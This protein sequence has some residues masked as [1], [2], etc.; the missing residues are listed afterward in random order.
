MECCSC[1]VSLIDLNS[2]ISA[3]LGGFFALLGVIIT[4]IWE[5][6]KIHQE[7][8]ESA[9]PFFAMIDLGDTRV[10]DSNNHVFIFSKNEC[11]DHREP[12][13]QANFIN[14]GK[15]EFLIEKISINNE[16]YFPIRKELISKDMAFM[17]K[18]NYE[19]DI[20]ENDVLMH[21]IDVNHNKRVYKLIHKGNV[22]TDF[23]LK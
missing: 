15:T 7:K 5:R 16:N 8:Q 6:I 2:L 18:F 17:I 21:V 23:K 9:N 19:E 12:H 10:I 22:I 3:L 11:F 14:S 20:K 13:L 4:I 1:L